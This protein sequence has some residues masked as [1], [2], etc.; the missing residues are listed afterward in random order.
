LRDV[1][2]FVFKQFCHELPAA[3]LQNVL[4]IISTPN[5]DAGQMLIAEGEED[6][7]EEDE[8]EEAE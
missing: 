3:N 2:N 5:V 7:E 4:D 6:I 8:E 1:A